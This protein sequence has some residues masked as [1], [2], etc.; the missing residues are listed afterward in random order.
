M[1]NLV[2]DCF[3]FSTLMSRLEFQLM[4]FSSSF[5][6][7]RFQFWRTWKNIYIEVRTLWTLQMFWLLLLCERSWKIHIRIQVD[8]P[9]SRSTSNMCNITRSNSQKTW[10]MVNSLLL[11][12]AHTMFANSISKNLIFKNKVWI[13][14]LKINKST[15]EIKI[16]EFSC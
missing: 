4:T 6:I 15:Y 5:L 10:S 12:K 11:N 13:F 16:F 8:D 9:R 2:Q 3:S 14:V 7:F 1:Q